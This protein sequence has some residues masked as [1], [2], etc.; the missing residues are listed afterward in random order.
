MRYK[1]PKHHPAPTPDPWLIW[2]FAQELAVDEM[3]VPR[4]QH[5]YCGLA[6]RPVGIVSEK[7]WRRLKYYFRTA[8]EELTAMMASWPRKKILRPKP[9]KHCQ[10]RGWTWSQTVPADP[11]PPPRRRRYLPRW[12]LPDVAAPP[13]TLTVPREG[14]PSRREPELAAIVLA[15]GFPGWK[16]AGP[17]RPKDL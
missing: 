6:E 1:L 9:K 15:T 7:N 13:R 3:D 11:H 2:R 16:N 10:L 17:T 5:R 14:R 8:H 4:Y 12:L